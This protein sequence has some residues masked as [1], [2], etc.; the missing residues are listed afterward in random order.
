MLESFILFLAPVIGTCTGFEISCLAAGVAF[1]ATYLVLLG[2]W[3]IASQ[4]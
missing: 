2:L 4:S 1:S 3:I